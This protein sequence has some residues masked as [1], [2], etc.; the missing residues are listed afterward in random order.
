MSILIELHESYQSRRV[1]PT[2]YFE[3]EELLSPQSTSVPK[4]RSHMHEIFSSMKS[5]QQFMLNAKTE[6]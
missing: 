6:R 3:M 2:K 1:Y 5:Q 4:V